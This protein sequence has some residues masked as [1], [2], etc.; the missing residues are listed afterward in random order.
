M[1]TLPF[2]DTL[3]SYNAFL[4]S[5][6]LTSINVIIKTAYHLWNLFKENPM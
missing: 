2:L 3:N 5:F 1:F 4:F 6:F